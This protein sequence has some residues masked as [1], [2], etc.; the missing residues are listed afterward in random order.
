MKKTERENMACF[1]I[2]LRGFSKKYDKQEIAGNVIFFKIKHQLIWLSD[3]KRKS[4][5]YVFNESM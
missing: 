3:L 4:L 1:K 2:L 5:L